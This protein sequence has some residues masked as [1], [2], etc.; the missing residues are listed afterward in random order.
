MALI[1]VN[2]R[3]VSPQGTDDVPY[4]A[5][6]RVDFIPVAHGKYQDSLRA[7]EKVSSPITDGVMAPVE[8]T[9]AF[10]TVTITPSKGNPWPEMLFELTEGMPEP[11]NLADL[12]PETV[13]NGTQLAKG[14]PGPSIKSWEDNGDGTVR[15]LLTDNTYTQSGTMPAGP[16]GP[17]G[18]VGPKGD[19]GPVG[20]Q[21]PEG[22]QGPKGDQGVQGPIG[23]AGMT[24]RGHWSDTIDY[25]NDDAVYHAGS[26]WFASGDPLLG[27]EPTEESIHWNALALRGA[28]G[29]QG[30]QGPQGPEGPQGPIGLT[31]D[32]GIQGVQGPIG[33]KGDTGDPGAVPTSTDYL[34]VGTGRPD[35]PDTTSMT[36]AQLSALPIGCEYRSTDGASVGAWVWRKQGTQ[37]VVTQGDTG[38]LDFTETVEGWSRGKF[39]VRRTESSV[40]AA[41][42]DLT[43][44][45]R[46]S[47]TPGSPTAS[48][49]PGFRVG[50]MTYV[51]AVYAQDGGTV[52][53]GHYA[54]IDF[55]GGRDIR[56]AGA[57]STL[58]LRDYMTLPPSTNPWPTT[59]P[60]S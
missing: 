41:F 29:I 25:S 50:G 60:G 43:F 46:P 51:G 12:L 59:L 48:L 2:L 54:R 19:Q 52:A 31:G 4:N 18:P 33:P 6:G 57:G 34:V 16:Q 1:T 17:Q 23:P 37:W 47:D 56:F 44:G 14:D 8:L 3:L 9:P 36:S 49:P 53:G 45:S 10:W 32:Q 24:W 42:D 21:G 55:I 15:F 58:W 30:E 38:W 20:P 27:E 22:I 7:I 39:K 13:I 35:I 26:S 28:Q 40:F 11:V 5:N